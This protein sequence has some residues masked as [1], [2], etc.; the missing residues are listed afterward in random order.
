MLKECGIGRTTLYQYFKN[1][2]EIFYCYLCSTLEV[3][4][5]QLKFIA[6][7]E[8]LT[9][10]EKLKKIIAYLVLEH[11]NIFILLIR[12]LGYVKRKA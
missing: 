12:S 8:Q 6:I 9:Y 1:K 2:D 10:V 4:E 3:M 7:N 5:S 11:S